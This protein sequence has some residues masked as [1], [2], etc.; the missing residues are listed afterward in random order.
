MTDSLDR[1]Q[2]VQLA[3]SA[4]IAA[5]L[6]AQTQTSGEADALRLWY[7]RPAA[8]WDEALPIG[9]GR[10]GAMVFGGVDAERL[11]LNE[12]TLYSEEP[13]QGDLPLDIQPEFGRVEELLRSGHYEEASALIT[14][15]WTGRSW[16]CYQPMADLEVRFDEQDAGKDAVAD[17]MRELDLSDSISRVRYTARGV[18]YTREYF[19]SFPDRVIVA[20]F[21]AS[22]EGSL[23]FDASLRSEHPTAHVTAS[24][25]GDLLLQGQA[26]G[27]V[28]RR[29]LE[30]VEKRGEQWKYPELWDANGKRH[31]YAKQVLYGNEVGGRGT[32]FATRLRV[33]AIGGTVSVSGDAVQVRGAREAVLILSAATS[34]NGPQK[35]PSREGV[36]PVALSERDIV[37]AGAK[38]FGQLRSRHT[39]DYRALF[40]RVSV[41]IGSASDAARRPTDERI[42]SFDEGKDPSFSALYLQF[43]R[44]LTI[45]G[46]RPG[47]QPLN[48]QGIWNREV[49][50]PWASGYTTN[51]NVEMN[52]WPVDTLHLSECFE[53]LQRL[54]AEAAV[55]GT[56]TASSM[57]HRKGWV[58]HHNTTLW[59]GTQP[60]D[61][62]ALPAFWN[63]GAGW[64]C[65]HL[66]EH[67][68][69][70]RDRAYLESVYPLMKGAA[71]FLSDWLVIGES[72][73]LVT[74]AG[75]S[76]ENSFK[77]VAED[78]SVKVGGVSMGPTMDIAITRQVFRNVIAAARTL[79]RDEA[80]CQDLQH[81][82]DQ[83]LPYEIGK[84]GQ[85]Q[86]W[87]TDF[88][89][90]Q[91]N[92]R[93]VSHL[94]GLYPDHQIDEDTPKLMAAAK[95]SLELRGDEGTGW[96]RAW[97]IC[98]WAR[99]RNGNHAYRLV[100]KLFQIAKTGEAQSELGG[101]M[102]NMFCS[103]PPM[104]IDGNFGGAAGIVEML[105]QS[106][107]DRIHLLPAL[108]DAWPEGSFRGFRTRAGCEVSARW[109]N[110]KLSSAEIT[111][112]HGGRVEIRY[113]E[114]RQMF[115]LKAGEVRE[116]ANP[117]LRL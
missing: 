11:Q 80:F 70:I 53:P 59:R 102:P 72:G 39:Q 115:I 8:D 112:T 14:K 31:P 117:L 48:L 97:K 82:M 17:Y 63:M 37:A 87:A 61:N 106:Q 90:T 3:G 114:A 23:S 109:K 9:S 50:P 71:E 55:S 98:L 78:G 60:V 113:G 7:G 27:F 73:K 84:A 18:E 28:L 92:H 29:T 58:L 77:Y 85:L 75:V 20:R 88:G 41:Q 19:A 64:L 36:D 91:P 104:Q 47:T 79:G 10:F 101:L 62:N 68:L 111:S 96:S 54:I 66:W 15:K 35:S 103:C 40:H 107:Q 30:W 5:T 89:E 45:S 83:L 12:D 57:Y 34:Y 74:A 25:K 38:G 94:Y 32:F 56:T 43:A 100:E 46:S 99:L 6:P 51:I 69:F 42:A 108:P 26:P 52:Y 4:A 76:P 44:Y 24:G 22:Q 93:H 105:L 116:I 33:T 49:I 81:R 65:E 21:Q 2:F 16:P 86:E 13:H 110:G 1:R 95:R 67:Y